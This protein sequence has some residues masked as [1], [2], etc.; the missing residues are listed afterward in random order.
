MSIALPSEQE[1]HRYN[2]KEDDLPKDF[3]GDPIHDL[4]P[5]I[6]SDKCDNEKD[7]YKVEKFSSEKSLTEIY[8]YASKVNQKCDR[9]DGRDIALA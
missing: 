2:R 9:G 1:T 4:L 7:R 3:C 5:D 6:R 8:R